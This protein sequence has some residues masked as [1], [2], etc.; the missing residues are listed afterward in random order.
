MYDNRCRRLF[1]YVDFVFYNIMEFYK[2]FELE[3]I[4]YTMPNGVVKTEEFKDIPGYEGLYQISCIG[5]IKSLERFQKNGSKLQKRPEIILS[6]VF[7]GHGYLKV[8]LSKEGK[9]KH[10]KTHL[11]IGMAFYNYFSNGTN[12]IVFDHKDNVPTHNYVG[13]FQPITNRLN[14]N[15]DKVGKLGY[16]GVRVSHKK[17][18]CSIWW[19]NKACNLGSYETPKE[20][21]EVREEALRL[22]EEGKCI[23]HLIRR[24]YK[25]NK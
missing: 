24:R 16:R 25:N 13:N 20:A 4:V 15:K 19:N 5:R 21:F 10:W 2:R 8:T 1:D 22:I 9:K 14:S 18:T 12:K 11:L 7:D 17:F 6:Q 23:E 3:N